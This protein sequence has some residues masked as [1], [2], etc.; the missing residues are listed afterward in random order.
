MWSN[1]QIYAIDSHFFF[2]VGVGHVIGFFQNEM[3]RFIFYQ[4]RNENYILFLE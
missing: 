4:Y 3:K 2:L 1:G